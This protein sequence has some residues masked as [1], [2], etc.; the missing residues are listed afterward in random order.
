MA[1]SSVKIVMIEA[2]AAVNNLLPFLATGLIAVN[3]PWIIHIKAV[4]LAGFD[5]YFNG[6]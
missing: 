4:T 5:S 3:V 1:V 2:A 6:T